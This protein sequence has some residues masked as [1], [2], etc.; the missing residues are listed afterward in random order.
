[1]ESGHTQ[2]EKKIYKDFCAKKNSVMYINFKW[3]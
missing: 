1:M 3:Y 2:K